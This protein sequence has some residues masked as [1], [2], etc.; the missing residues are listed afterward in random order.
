MHWIGFN[1]IT[2]ASELFD[3][4]FNSRRGYRTKELIIIFYTSEPVNPVVTLQN[5]GLH[6]KIITNDFL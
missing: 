3:S 6:T 4:Q 2:I 1:V 5:P